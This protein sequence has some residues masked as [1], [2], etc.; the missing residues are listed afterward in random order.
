MSNMGFAIFFQ[1]VASLGLVGATIAVIVQILKGEFK[2]NRSKKNNVDYRKL[3]LDSSNP[4]I[5]KWVTRHG[6]STHAL[7]T[8]ATIASDKLLEDLK[9]TFPESE[10][11]ERLCVDQRSCNTIFAVKQ[12]EQEVLLSINWSSHET[13]DAQDRPYFTA[14]EFEIDNFIQEGRMSIGYGTEVVSD[15]DYNDPMVKNILAIIKQSRVDRQYYFDDKEEVTTL[16]RLQFWMDTITFSPYKVPTSDYSAEYIDTAYAAADVAYEGEKHSLKMSSVLNLVQKTIELKK[17]VCLFGTPGTGKTTLLEAIAARLTSDSRRYMPLFLPAA[18]VSQLRDTQTM[19]KFVEEVKRQ[20]ENGREIVLMLDESEILL[21]ASTNGI[22]TS[23]ATFMLNFLDGT[24]SRELG[25]AT[26]LVFNAPIEKL[27]PA[28]FRSMRM[29]MI[30]IHLGPL[31]ETQARALVLKL[32]RTLPGKIFDAKAFEKVLRETNRMTDGTTYAEAGYMSLAD[33][34][35]CFLDQDYRAMLLSFIR[36]ESM[37][38]E[39][40]QKVAAPVA[41]PVKVKRIKLTAPQQK[42][43]VAAPAVPAETQSKATQPQK[44]P[45]R[46]RRRNKKNK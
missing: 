15:L 18:T 26:I 39:T 8:T 20:Q 45:R 16:H 30:P 13:S 10:F 22:H 9:L 21:A 37:G 24:T 46:D 27:N 36:K 40:P 5:E 41:S 25:I 34:Y 23:D 29:G 31:A 38:T 17:N 42:E 7:T 14:S 32:K 28:V 12:G 43:D 35:A 2:K 1:A 6:T 3:K 11:L 19:A 44:G 33:I 4:V